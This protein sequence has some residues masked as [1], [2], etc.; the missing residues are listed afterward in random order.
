MHTMGVFNTFSNEDPDQSSMNMSNRL[1]PSE[2][3]EK[4]ENVFLDQ[5]WK[6]LA[7][8]NPPSEASTQFIHSGLVF[9]CVMILIDTL[10]R[11]ELAARLL[12]E[13]I[14]KF[15]NENSAGKIEGLY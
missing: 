10:L 4:H 6:T 15:Y 13:R 7:L 9:D 14:E 8:S 5:L 12:K 1:K 2:Q 11:K 3:R